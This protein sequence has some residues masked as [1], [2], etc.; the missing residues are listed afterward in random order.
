MKKFPSAGRV[1]SGTQS[2]ERA[3][4]VLRQVVSAPRAGLSLA[5]IVQ[6]LDLSRPTV[7]RLASCLER[8]QFLYR[9]PV[10]KHY[11][12][13]DF[14][15]NLSGSVGAHE[16]LRKLC[17][18]RMRR[19]A[20]R[21]GHTLYLIVR[22]GDDGRCI[23]RQEGSS[24]VRIVTID[25]GT[26][27]PLGVGAAGLALLAALPPEEQR[28]VL[29]RNQHRY[30]LFANLTQTRI[31]QLLATARRQGYAVNTAQSS[32]GVRSV[33]HVLRNAAG[34]AIAALSVSGPTQQIAKGREELAHLLR[35]QAREVEKELGRHVTA[36]PLAD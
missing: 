24:A 6:A 33:G 20:M 29:D 32:L 11:V 27:R 12:L 15:A 31:R 18:E 3:A 14:F 34:D 26:Q 13:G 17:E 16:S 35:T 21:T 28:E 2:V 10:T 8:E 36:L 25:E 30:G 5:Q 9:D 23:L 1:P 7:F 22:V 19:I 4:Q